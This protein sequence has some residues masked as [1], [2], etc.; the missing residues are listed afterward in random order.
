MWIEPVEMPAHLAE[1]RA[2][3]L[4]KKLAQMQPREIG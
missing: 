3:G 4:V 2:I 1:A